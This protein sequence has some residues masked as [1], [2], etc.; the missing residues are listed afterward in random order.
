MGVGKPEDFTKEQIG[1][2]MAGEKAG[3]ET[4]RHEK[5]V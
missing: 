3:E 4:V 2:M 5:S 1:L